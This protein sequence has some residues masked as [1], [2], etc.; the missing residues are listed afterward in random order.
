MTSICP[1]SGMSK[2]P[3][4]HAVEVTRFSPSPE[5]QVFQLADLDEF[6]EVLKEAESEPLVFDIRAL[7]D[8]QNVDRGN[9]ILFLNGHRAYLRLLE[10]REFCCAKSSTTAVN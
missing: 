3:H 9:F 5:T 8:A 6:R 7:N 2:P 4:Y 10:H 1:T